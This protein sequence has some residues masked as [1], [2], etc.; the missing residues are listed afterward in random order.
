ME[1][2]TTRENKIII[3]GFYHEWTHNGSKTVEEQVKNMEVFTK[4]IEEV[5]KRTKK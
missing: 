3:G 4:Q 1:I 5:T 2:N